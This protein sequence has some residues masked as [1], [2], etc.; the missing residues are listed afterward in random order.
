MISTTFKYEENAQR[1]LIEGAQTFNRCSS[2]ISCVPGT[3]L[4][5]LE[6]IKTSWHPHSQGSS[7]QVEKIQVDRLGEAYG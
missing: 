6:I 5:T 3:L 1:L 7:S 4:G 2:N